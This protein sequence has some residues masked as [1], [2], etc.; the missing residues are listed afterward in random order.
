[1]V[2]H[3]TMENSIHT[4]D[5]GKNLTENAFTKTGSSFKGIWTTNADGT[6]EEFADGEYVINLTSEE[7][8]ITLYAQW[9][10]NEYTV[11]FNPNGGT[12]ST[13]T[14]K[15]T[16]GANYG[17][18]PT[19]TREGYK[20]V[21]WYI[22]GNAGAE[23]PVDAS[24]TV[25]YE[26]NHTLY[27]KWEPIEYKIRYNANGASGTMADSVHYYGEE[28][29]LTA[30]SF[31]YTGYKFLK[32]NTKADGSGIDY[33]DK[34]KIK[35]L[36]NVDGTII[37][38]YAQWTQDEFTV[39][40]D[41]STN[42]GTSA[43]K[44]TAQV[45]SGTAV[46]LTPTATKSGWIFV[47]WN[48]SKTAT[49]A[50]TSLTMGSSDI[51]L[52]AIYSKTITATFYYYS[53]GIKSE[54]ASKTIYNTATSATLSIPTA[55]TESKGQYTNNYVGLAT[56]TSSMT[57]DVA[58]TNTTV[59]ISTNKA[60]YALYRINV[61][62]YYYDDSSS[63]GKSRTVYRNSFFTSVSAMNTV[64]SSS[65]TG[66][67][68]LSTKG[69]GWAGYATTSSADRSYAAVENAAKSTYTKLYSVYSDGKTITFYYYNGSAQTSTTL[70]A[71]SRLNYTKTIA[72]MS[73]DTINEAPSVVTS[74]VGPNGTPYYGLA[75][76]ANTS[77][78]VNSISTANSEYYAVYYRKLTVVLD[79]PW[80]S[81]NGYG[82]QTKSAQVAQYSKGTEY[83][84]NQ[85]YIQMSARQ[86]WRERNGRKMTLTGTSTPSGTINF[87]NNSTSYLKLASSSTSSGTA[88]TLT[89]ASKGRTWVAA[90]TGKSLTEYDIYIWSYIYVYNLRV[91]GNYWCYHF[92]N[93]SLYSHGTTSV[94]WYIHNGTSYSFTNYS[95]T[96]YRLDGDYSYYFTRSDCGLESFKCFAA[97]GACTWY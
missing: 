97:S 8:T 14:K 81:D 34:Q 43:T 44:T 28:K 53:G 10:E 46:D 83:T 60:Y 37:N 11:T 84:S 25:T 76:S 30:N 82:V 56:A 75:T 62:E 19:P 95:G 86:E 27:A 35:N 9:I 29:A 68:N 64:L 88:N 80:W 70:T 38:L 41:Y 23:T 58:S 15:V 17:T 16:Y 33:T 90:Y 39:T 21:Y 66:T 47:G 63:A 6:G 85:Q 93:N 22:S 2:A 79:N 94:G 92:Q 78:I 18:L 5:V 24:T 74:S 13:S 12:T 71:S 77:T 73:T 54:A 50:L 72:V 57:A 51:T 48:T 91:S 69:A 3:G 65:S 55:V 36:T 1:M 96:F 67:E 42:G 45:L 20:F 59:T 31:T 52:Y 7:T 49:T 87:N 4:Y 32:W 61:T 89:T 40:Y 26:G